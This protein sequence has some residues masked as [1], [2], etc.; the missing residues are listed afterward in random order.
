MDEWD[1]GEELVVGDVGS[2]MVADEWLMG[3]EGLVKERRV[4]GGE[5]TAFVRV[6]NNTITP[7]YSELQPFSSYLDLTK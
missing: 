7:E 4:T 2:K 1:E 3:E 6:C 5:S